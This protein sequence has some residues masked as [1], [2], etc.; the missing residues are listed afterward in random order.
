[1]I[2]FLQ[3]ILPVKF[4]VVEIRIHLS[5]DSQFDMFLVI[6]IMNVR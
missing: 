2:T 6:I 5:I 4:N 1:M 3:Q